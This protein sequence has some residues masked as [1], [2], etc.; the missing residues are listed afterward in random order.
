MIGFTV[1]MKQG[2]TRK[3]TA[4]FSSFERIRLGYAAKVIMIDLFSL[5]RWY[6]YWDM[7]GDSLSYRIYSEREGTVVVHIALA[8]RLGHPIQHTYRTQKSP[9]YS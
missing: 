6:C 2:T 9:F 1:S 4:T 7:N 8:T 3:G 5:I